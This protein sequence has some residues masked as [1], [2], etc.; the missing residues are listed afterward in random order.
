MTCPKCGSE[1]CSVQ[2]VTET[3]IKQK[4]HGVLYWLIIGWWLQPILWIFLTLPMLIISIFK[5]KKYKI[6]NTQKKV[7]VCNSCGNSWNV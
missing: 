2:V 4:K 5:P 1:N 7:V 6:Q 3:T